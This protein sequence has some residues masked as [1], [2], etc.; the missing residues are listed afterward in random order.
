MTTADDQESKRRQVR[1]RPTLKTIARLSG[2]AV[3]TVSRALNEAPDISDATKVRVRAIARDIG[4][5][6]DRAGLRLRTG[7]TQVIS[8]VLS[9]DHEFMNHTVKLISSVAA[10]LRGSGYHMIVTP[11]F[12]RE[13][14][15]APIRYLVE[16]GSADGV[17]LNQIEPEDPRVGYLLSVGIP[18]ATHGRTVWS[19]R[20]PWY[21]FDNREYARQGVRALAARGRRQVA[22]IAPPFSQN[23]S[24]EMRGGGNEAAREAGVAFEVLPDVTSHDRSDDIQAALMRRLREG[25]AVDGIVCASTTSCMAAVA[26]AESAGMTVGE[27]VDVVGKEAIPFLTVFRSAILTFTEDVGAAG[28]FLAGAL[29]RQIAEPERPPIGHLE[30]PGPLPEADRPQEAGR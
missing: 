28:T 15:M 12:P 19:D 6:P 14:P 10:G 20:H 26:A 1:E 18:V 3:T 27:E 17:I 22:M 8:L 2:L 25:P 4:Y 5:R 13:D 30:V 9:T 7:R 11:Y 29:L 16:S 24:I 21:D 23:Y